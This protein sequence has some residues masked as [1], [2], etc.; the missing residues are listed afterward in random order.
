MPERWE[1][2][3]REL[4]RMEPDPTA[5]RQR[6]E[7]GPAEDRMPPR[8]DRIVAGVVAAVVAVA[9]GTFAW[10]TLGPAT[11]VGSVDAGP[12]PV[13]TVSFSMLEE[14]G[15]NRLATLSVGGSSQTGVVGEST[16]PD[17]PY[18]YAWSNP[19][20][21]SMA[22]PL[23][24]PMGSELRLEG[25][26]AI[27]E[28]LYGDADRLDAG[29]GPDSGPIYSNQPDFSVPYFFPWD[30][31]PERMYLKFFG[32]WED[33]QVLD[34]YFEV[35]FVAP[36]VDLTDPSAEIVV[37]PEPMDAAFVYGGQRSPMGLAGGTYGNTSTVSEHAG[38]D[39]AAI[40]VRIPAGTPFE[41]GGDRLVEATVRAGPLPYGEGGTLLQGLVPTEVGRYVLTMDVT[42]DGG[43]LR[44]CT[45]SRSCRPLSS[46]G[47]RVRRLSRH[48][49]RAPLGAW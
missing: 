21:P 47:R 16:S 40:V 11:N 45:R 43:P 44:S 6:V 36:D 22:L 9:A 10:R 24:V 49:L 31:K 35:V 7:R 8:R 42:W 30:E 39:E 13:A 4:R 48:R 34:V 20:L 1:R 28:L 46:V 19:T 41:I 14:E 33:G 27:R 32:T 29:E 23:E 12:W 37:T 15:N 25:D 2:E 38:Y 18:P 5:V 3:L 26:V 17:E